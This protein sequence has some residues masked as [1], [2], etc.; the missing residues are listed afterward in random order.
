MTDGDIVVSYDPKIEIVATCK[1]CGKEVRIPWLQTPVPCGLLM[2][3]IRSKLLDAGWEVDGRMHALCPEHLPKFDPLKCAED[4]ID[5][6]K[7]TDSKRINGLYSEN[8][9]WNCRKGSFCKNRHCS[10]F[11]TTACRSY[12]HDPYSEHD[13]RN[14]VMTLDIGGG[15][16]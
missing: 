16:S 5:K 1:K 9:C 8:G 3:D 15:S 11:D 13:H 7:E 14:I 6:L 10:D 4:T 2:S 12:S